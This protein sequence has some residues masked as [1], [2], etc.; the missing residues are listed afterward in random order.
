MEEKDDSIKL[1][2]ETNSG[3][4]MGVQAIEDV[5]FRIKNEKLK[6][7]LESS[8]KEHQRLGDETHDMLIEY[9]DDIKEA[10][11]IVKEMSRMKIEAKMSWDEEDKTAAGLISDGCHMGVKSL[12]KYLNQYKKAEKKAR[13]IAEKLISMEESLDIKMRA[14]L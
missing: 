12:S 13:D 6:R 11:P 2:R 3:I 14:Y 7:I 9:G 8:M 10:H 1:L 4:Q 5:L